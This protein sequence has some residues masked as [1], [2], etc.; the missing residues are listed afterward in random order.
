MARQKR[1]AKHNAKHKKKRA[2]NPRA[3]RRLV[4]AVLALCVLGGLV[5]LSLTV[6]FPVQR[7]TAEGETRV[8]K[9]EHV[10]RGCEHFEEDLALLG[11]HITREDNELGQ[12]DEACQT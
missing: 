7:C 10:D 8:R 6:L 5:A 9:I 11:A 3:S 1:R 4:K 12:T 2:M